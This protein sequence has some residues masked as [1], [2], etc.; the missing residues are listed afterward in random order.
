M[1]LL[2]TTVKNITK[3]LDRKLPW[4]VLK[5]WKNIKSYSTGYF[6]HYSLHTLRNHAWYKIIN[7]NA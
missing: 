4:R 6:V 2:A 7:N 5:A 3:Q 1:Q